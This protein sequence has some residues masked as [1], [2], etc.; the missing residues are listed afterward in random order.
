MSILDDEG[1][2]VE[3]DT[4][5]SFELPPAEPLTITDMLLH[6]VA[7]A[8]DWE[9]RDLTLELYKWYDIFNVRLFADEPLR[10]PILGFDELN[11]RTLAQFYVTRNQLG[12][13]N[14]INLNFKH[15]SL[16]GSSA[17]WLHGTWAFLETLLHEML[18]SWQDTYGLHK[19]SKIVIKQKKGHN[20]E[21]IAKAESFGLHVQP[22]DGW[23]TDIA[24]GLFA[25]LMTEYNI[26]PLTDVPPA[27]EDDK[28]NYWKR[29]KPRKWSYRQKI[30]KWLCPTCGETVRTKKSFPG[31]IC[32]M[33]NEAYINISP[34][35]DDAG[36]GADA[37]TD[38][39]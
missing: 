15:I 3:D 26:T 14:V 22:E 25:E 33:C 6:N 34:R 36:D 37:V 1:L 2:W 28:G 32:L 8:N 38:G 13:Y 7:E 39:D 21:Y 30:N 29:G 5:E 16:D 24:T 17:T 10:R 12:L 31:C 27:Q 4:G 35:D 18:H 23:H 9:V 11:I 19:P 20:R